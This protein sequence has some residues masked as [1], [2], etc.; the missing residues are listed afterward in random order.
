MGVQVCSCIQKNQVV[1]LS[2]VQVEVKNHLKE[3]ISTKTSTEK[4]SF[5]SVPS[6]NKSFSTKSLLDNR[7]VPPAINGDKIKHKSCHSSHRSQ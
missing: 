3:K 1:P 6:P 2:H 5:T 4:T 7:Y